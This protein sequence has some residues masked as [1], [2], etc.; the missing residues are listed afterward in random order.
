MQQL[1][2][3]GWALG[4]A[5]LAGL[6]LY[7]TVFVTGLAIQ[8]HWIDVAATHPDLLILAHP[9]VLVVSGVLYLLE[10]FA[11]KIP[12][13][14]SLWDAVHTVIRPIGGAL[15]AIRVLGNPDPV[16]DVIVALLGG[17]ASLLVHGVKSGTRLVVN[18]SPEP[19][20]NIGLSVAEDV[21][22]LGG[23]ALM[24]Y[25]PV[26]ALGVFLVLLA[27]ICY[28]GPLLYRVAKVQL[29]LVWKKIGSPASD[30]PA[31]ELE[32]VLPA[33][34]DV[35]F[36]AS[37]LL[38]E[39]ITWAAPC[40]S[41][42]ARGIPGNLFGQLIAT[43]EQTGKVWFV[44]RRGWRKLAVELDVTGYKVAR[45]PKFLSENLV[46]YSLA[47]KPKYLFVF[48]RPQAPLVEAVATSLRE[49]IGI[50][51]PAPSEPEAAPVVPVS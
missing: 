44:A 46:L 45:E 49:R 13:V 18:H 31:A 24:R 51:V 4:L 14:D 37:N 15:L 26:L 27:A 2:T 5:S 47:K 29:W 1:Q 10:F 35:I 17:G 6:N 7:L 38:G 25:D 11:D 34:L 33:E 23:L 12:W 8:Q 40:I 20:S 19:F 3:L 22:V 41:G 9:V 39:K 48:S 50:P 30:K 42:A 32:A 21:T 36:H 28:F 43:A 16:F